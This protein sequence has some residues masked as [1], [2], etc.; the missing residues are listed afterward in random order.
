MGGVGVGAQK[1]DNGKTERAQRI[2]SL[3]SSRLFWKTTGAAYHVQIQTEVS[4]FTKQLL[5]K[6]F[7]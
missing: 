3:D 2:E 7:M 1:A 5:K 4:I 6:K